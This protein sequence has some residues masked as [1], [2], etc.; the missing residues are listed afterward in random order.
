MVQTYSLKTFSSPSTLFL[1]LTFG[2][3]LTIL[4]TDKVIA[5]Q[6]DYV[7]GKL[8][9]EIKTR[10]QNM[11][12]EYNQELHKPKHHGLKRWI[13]Q[14]QITK[15]EKLETQEPRNAYHFYFK[16]LHFTESFIQTL[17]GLPYIKKV[18]QIPIKTNVI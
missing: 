1:L 3:L 14:Y 10:Y 7:E 11:N 15:I 16:K 5:N 4:N 12:W 18:A 8:Y 2:F 9:V 6:V 17:N 13:L